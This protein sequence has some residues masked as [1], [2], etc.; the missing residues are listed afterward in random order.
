MTC[1]CP[2]AMSG[3]TTVDAWT[4]AGFKARELADRPTDSCSLATTSDG[5]SPVTVPE[6]QAAGYQYRRDLLLSFRSLLPTQPAGCTLPW[7]VPTETVWEPWWRTPKRRAR[8]AEPKLPEEAPAGDPTEA[9]QAEL[10]QEVLPDLPQPAPEDQDFLA[11]S[12]RSRG[13]KRQPAVQVV[14]SFHARAW[15]G[16][17]RRREQEDLLE[18]SKGV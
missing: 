2:E 11:A 6:V 13:R 9:L 10:V 5:C 3:E 7:L 16:A 1:F 4:V 17:R 14:C 18:S 12:V 15:P 8:R